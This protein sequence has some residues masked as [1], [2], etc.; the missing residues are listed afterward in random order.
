M[1]DIDEGNNG[2]V[3]CTLMEEKMEM[4]ERNGEENERWIAEREMGWNEGW[5]RERK[6]GWNKEVEYSK[7]ASSSKTHKGITEEWKSWEKR[8]SKKNVIRNGRSLSKVE[9]NSLNSVLQMS[10]IFEKEYMLRVAG[11]LDREKQDSY[12]FVVRLVVWKAT[13][14]IYT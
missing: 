7:G 11:A 13:L 9:K 10:M 1:F 14:N 3:T 12:D 5:S 2:E 8:L 6:K 4:F